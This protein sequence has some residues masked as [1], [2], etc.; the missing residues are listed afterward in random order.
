[1]I[2]ATLITLSL[3]RATLIALFLIFA[4]YGARAANN[5]NGAQCGSDSECMRLCP[6]EDA[7]CDGGPQSI[8]LT[9]V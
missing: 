2:H 5:N 8:N 6:A 1:M 9:E 4:L 7:Q 3:L